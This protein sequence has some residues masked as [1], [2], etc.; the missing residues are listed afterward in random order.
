[1]MM[2]MVLPLLSHKTI[3]TAAKSQ[4]ATRITEGGA[5]ESSHPQGEQQPPK[6]TLSGIPHQSLNR[7]TSSPDYDQQPIATV[8]S[9]PSTSTPT[10]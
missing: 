4:S 2:K 6:K 10:L 5:T 8:L 7:S 9:K 3:S 1:M